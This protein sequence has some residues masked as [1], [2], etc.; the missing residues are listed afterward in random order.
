M[1]SGGKALPTPICLNSSKQL[2]ADAAGTRNIFLSLLERVLDSATLSGKAGSGA[3]LSFL[4]TRFLGK[5][6]EC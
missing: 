4:N 2:A 5:G 6:D 3:G 1:T